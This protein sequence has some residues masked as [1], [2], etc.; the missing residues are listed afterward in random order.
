MSLCACG[1][2]RRYATLC[3]NCYKRQLRATNPGYKARQQKQA[4]EIRARDPK[5]L[6]QKRSR[7]LRRRYGI[8]LVD[9]ERMLQE[10]RGLCRICCK[11]PTGRGLVVDHNHKTGKVRGLLCWR[12]NYGLGWFHDE[13]QWFHAACEY[14]KEG[15]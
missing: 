4:A 12:C 2:P 6:R 14:L 5:H 1:K 15:E 11:V 9:Y 13:A 7:A 8:S 10:Q 3:D